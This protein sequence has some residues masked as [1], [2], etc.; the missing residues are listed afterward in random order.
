[1]IPIVIRDCRVQINSMVCIFFIPS[2]YICGGFFPLV[3][4]KLNSGVYVIVPFTK[5]AQPYP[6]RIKLGVVRNIHVF[7]GTIASKEKSFVY[8]KI[9]KIAPLI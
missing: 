7:A 1:M 3:M 5:N 8:Q 4:L 6:G 2:A 9:L